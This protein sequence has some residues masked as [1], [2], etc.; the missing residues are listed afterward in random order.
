MTCIAIAVTGPSEKQVNASSKEAS[1]TSKKPTKQ[2][3]S[4]VNL[5][6][7]LEK[8]DYSRDGI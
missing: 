7:A 4:Q 3:K 2:D 8:T 6:P 5:H 1:P